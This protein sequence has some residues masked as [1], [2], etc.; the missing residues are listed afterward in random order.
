LLVCRKNG[1]ELGGLEEDLR[2]FGEDESGENS[3]ASMVYMLAFKTLT[4]GKSIEGLGALWS[5]CQ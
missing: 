1:Y 4:I 5:V 2:L 3:E